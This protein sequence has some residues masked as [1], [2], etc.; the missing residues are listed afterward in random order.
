MAFSEAS[1]YL[2]NQFNPFTV[3]PFRMNPLTVDLTASKKNFVED[4]QLTGYLGEKE[5]L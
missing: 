2:N 4:S 3:N 1:L 5:L